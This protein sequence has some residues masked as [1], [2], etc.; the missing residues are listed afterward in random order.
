VAQ[1]LMRDLEQLKKDILTMG[2]MVEEAILK[3]T[4]SLVHRRPD[5]AEE[6]IANDD[7][8]DQKEL[9]VENECLKLLA[10][11]QPVAK[12]LRFIIAI[13]KVNNDLERMGD[14]AV[15][16]AE[17]ALYLGDHPAIPIPQ[18]L[19]E[20]VRNVGT[21]VRDSLD[22]LVNQDPGLARGVCRADDVV[23]EFNREMYRILEDVMQDDPSTIGRAL[24]TLSASR[25]LERIAD[26]ATN[27][28]E[29]IV[30][31]VEGEVIK[32]RSGKFRED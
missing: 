5:L 24:N 16:I 17:R 4:N 9:A 12:D 22:A 26:A 2:A 28:A 27:I 3:A 13:M 31:M 14:L 1:H 18:E 10:L 7:V 32:H 15:N 29:D 23:D 21:M 25:N 8:I 11:H 6:V 20:M 19:K 30:F